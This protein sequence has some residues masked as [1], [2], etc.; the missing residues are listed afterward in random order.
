MSFTDVLIVSLRERGA[1]RTPCITGP[2]TDYLATAEPK[3]PDL[4]RLQREVS[5]ARADNTALPN[6]PGSAYLLQSILQRIKAAT[7]TLSIVSIDPGKLSISVPHSN[8]GQSFQQKTK[9]RQ[10]KCNAA[11]WI[12][13]ACIS[14]CCICNK[15]NFHIFLWSREHVHT[16][17]S[18][19]LQGY[20][21]H[22]P[23]G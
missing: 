5:S 9:A 11:A 12:S 14:F 17:P 15:C 7:P 23:H 4:W 20:W 1:Q 13:L 18:S 2:D 3:S 22:A 19:A 6:R 21:R 16:T 10:R 8:N